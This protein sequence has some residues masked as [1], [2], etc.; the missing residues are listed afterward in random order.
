[1]SFRKRNVVVQGSA[2]S[3]S[4][5]VVSSS[6]SPRPTPGVRASPQSGQAVTSTGTITLDG[7][8][9]GH[10]GLLQGSSLLIE[11]NGTTDFAGSLLK[12]YAAQGIV[13]GHT[14]HII[15]A[16]EQWTRAL[17]GV[18][19]AADASSD[20]K[21]VKRGA[22]DAEKMKIA[23]RYE[24]LG[25]VDAEQKARGWSIL[26]HP[27]DEICIDVYISVE[28]RIDGE[29]DQSVFC[30]SFD[31]AK[32]LI[33]GPD[34]SIHY[35]NIDPMDPAPFTSVVESLSQRLAASKDS[36][37]HRVV[38]PTLLSPAI[39]S[40]ASGHPHI[41]LAFLHSLRAL[42]RRH[43]LTTTIMLSLPLGLYPRQ[44]GLVRWIEHICDGVMELTPFPH[45][46]DADSSDGL[47]SGIDEQP[48]GMVK[49]HKLPHIT[50]KG[51]GG[52]GVN[53]GD[54]LAFTQSRRKFVIKPFSLPPIEGD[55]DAQKGEGRSGNMPSKAD[56]EF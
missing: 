24:R 36:T 45:A 18:I 40:A 10:S 1:M 19:G 29:A 33:V 37:V 53:A 34:A 49:L 46:M 16:D 52:S 25:Q 20:Q 17:P 35:Y 5:P 11:E 3:Q 15:G 50:E 26:V 48:Q 22:V 9:G 54:D 42:L 12:F 4:N 27:V 28:S 55:S 32:R 14:L 7:L 6:P 44:T 47:P 23:W 38:I 21:P 39:Y 8:L 56:I 30:N 13:H 51:R 31:L 41:V 43:S 2:I